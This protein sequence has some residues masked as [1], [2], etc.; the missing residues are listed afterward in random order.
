MVRSDFQRSLMEIKQDILRMGSLVEEA[1]YNAVQA[2][3]N[4]DI[5]LAS[6]VIAGDDAI[7]DLRNEIENECI[8]LIATQQ[9]MAKDLRVMVSGIK[10]V[11]SLERMADHAVDIAKIAMCGVAKKPVETVD[12]IKQMAVLAQNMVKDSL[13]AYVQGDVAKARQMCQQ[14]NQVDELY[15]SIFK[16]L[17]EYLTRDVRSV[18]DA[19]SLLFVSRFLERIADHANNIGRNVIYLVTGKKKGKSNKQVYCELKE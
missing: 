17:N 3:V 19:T 12:K 9:P 11:T 8:T 1:I 7:D 15:Y 4:Q 13:D 5:M 2:L 10:I 16:E 6:T 18:T 14:D